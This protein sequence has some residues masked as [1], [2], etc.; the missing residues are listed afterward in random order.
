[1]SFNVIFGKVS[2]TRCPFWHQLLLVF[3]FSMPPTQVWLPCDLQDR[4]K[5]R[6]GEKGKTSD[7]EDKDFGREAGGDWLCAR[8]WKTEVWQRDKHRC[9][10]L[11]EKHGWRRQEEGNDGMFSRNKDVS[12]NVMSMYEL[13]NDISSVNNILLWMWVKTRVETTI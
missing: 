11:K 3:F 1:M 9:L 6:Q 13:S 2:T 12:T 10:A 5:N 4:K 8:H 7:Y